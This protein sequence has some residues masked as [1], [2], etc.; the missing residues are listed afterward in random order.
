MRKKDGGPNEICQTDDFIMKRRAGVAGAPP[1][2]WLNTS[3][4]WTS[5]ASFSRS[6][7]FIFHSALLMLGG[8][9]IS[10]YID[11][12]KHKKLNGSSGQSFIQ[13]QTSLRFWHAVFFQIMFLMKLHSPS[14]SYLFSASALKQLLD[15][16]IQNVS[17][18][19]LCCRWFS[20]FK[21]NSF[22]CQIQMGTTLYSFLASSQT[23]IC[24]DL[25]CIEV[26][27]YQTDCPIQSKT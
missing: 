15:Y 8:N 17:I 16:W 5:E 10:V 9:R 27:N 3:G 11:D 19:S 20:V 6:H 25:C 4:R 1:L 23:K 24:P 7:L 12:V 26:F 13:V 21:S 22:G 18:F 14:S 2:N